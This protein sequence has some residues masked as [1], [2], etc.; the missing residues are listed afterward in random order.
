MQKGLPQNSRGQWEFP[1]VDQLLPIVE[2]AF[3]GCEADYGIRGKIRWSGAEGRP[4]AELHTKRS[5]GVELVVFCPG[6]RV[7]IGSIADHGA[8][9]QVEPSRDGRDAVR[10][11]F[12]TAKQVKA[13]ALKALLTR[14]QSLE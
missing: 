9:Q 8:S 11:L 10:M 6:G 1:V 14:L 3:S 4:A 13:T 7:T 12:K 2:K 5:D